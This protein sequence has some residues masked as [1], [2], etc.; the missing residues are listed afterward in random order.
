MQV[1]L[2][3]SPGM[4]HKC[5]AGDPANTRCSPLTHSD[6]NCQFRR[7][8]P[9]R[10]P[11]GNRNVKVMLQIKKTE[12]P[13]IA[14]RKLFDKKNWFALLI[15]FCNTLCHIT[16]ACIFPPSTNSASPCQTNHVS[17]REQ[18]SV[19]L[20]ESYVWTTELLV[21]CAKGNDASENFCGVHL[22]TAFSIEGRSHL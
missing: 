4:L 14:A 7:E 20:K 15:H 1:H 2:V 12:G 21:M 10:L 13:T 11:V 8:C 6:R 18:C 22:Q 5:H 3:W 19:T 17:Q 16:L 9:Q